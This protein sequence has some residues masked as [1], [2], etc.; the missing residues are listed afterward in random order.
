MNLLP[1]FMRGYA[2][3]SCV[4]F[5]GI[6]LP[7]TAATVGHW[8]FESGTAFLA[9]SGGHPAGPFTLTNEG[10]NNA[11]D[12]LVLVNTGFGAKFPRVL[13]KTGAANA[14]AAVFNAAEGDGFTAVHN[15]A[16][17]TDAFTIEAIVNL[18]STGVGV[19]SHNIATKYAATISERMFRLNVAGTALA[20]GVPPRTLCLSIGGT[21]NGNAVTTFFTS[22]LTLNEGE[23]HYVAVSFRLVPGGAE[24]VFYLKNLTRGT[25]MEVDYYPVVGLTA[26]NQSSAPFRIGAATPVAGQLAWDGVIDEVRFSNTALSQADLLIATPVPTIV[27]QPVAHTVAI[28]AI[29]V[30][31]VDVSSAVTPTYQWFHNGVA[32]PGFTFPFL[33][34]RAVA[35]GQS[36]TYTCQVSTDGGTV[37]TTGAVFTIVNTTDPGKLAALSIRGQVGT[38][39]D[40]M[41][42]GLITEG[43]TVNTIIQAVGPTLGVEFPSLAG[44]VLADPK[45]ELHRFKDGAF[46]S[47]QVNDDWGRSP[48]ITAAETA[49][50]ATVLRADKDS[51]FLNTLSPGVYTATVSVNNNTTGIALLQAYAVPSPQDT[52]QLSALSIRGQVG[53]GSDVMVAGIIVGGST[54]KTLIIQAVGPTLGVLFP[55]LQ[56]SVLVNPKLELYQLVNGAFVKILEND[57]WGGD[58]NIATQ[59]SASGA[60][61]LSSSTSK[62]SALL[63]TLPP[64]VYTANVSGVNNTSGVVLLQ[65]YSVP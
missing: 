61:V 11:N 58:A 45:M 55:S 64:G 29:A 34:L 53:T 14:G 36:G 51:A 9:D 24:M 22:F 5:L 15:A 35:T 52:G 30:L 50:G 13:A 48:Q 54:A 3:R 6:C 40:V 31:Q 60:T 46:V 32:M 49:V 4:L 27:K 20:P 28:N 23:D 63:V 25:P 56:S 8:R 44:V 62:D 7:V 39:N 42:A 18:G 59:Q 2:H 17:N 57:D 1:A 41:V 37:V 65:A 21:Q 26:I 12:S 43:S 16:F 10:A 47:E 38:G 19:V 33:V